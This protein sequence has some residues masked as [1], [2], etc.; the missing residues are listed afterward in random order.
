M[1]DFCKSDLKLVRLCCD[2]VVWFFDAVVVW[3]CRDVVVWRC[4]VFVVLWFNLLV[5]LW[6]S[7]DCA[8]WCGVSP[9]QADHSVTVLYVN[10]NTIHS[11]F[12]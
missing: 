8:G 12:H 10:Y 4:C 2:F 3:C 1:D 11:L 7:Q 9:C 5:V 6:C